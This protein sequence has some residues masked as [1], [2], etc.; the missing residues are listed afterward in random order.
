MKGTRR[1]KTQGRGVPSKRP[2]IQQIVA[3]IKGMKVKDILWL[4]AKIDKL[5]AGG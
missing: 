5:I 2:S 3:A 1:T 4:R